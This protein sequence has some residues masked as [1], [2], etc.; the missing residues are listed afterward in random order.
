MEKTFIGSSQ[1]M[2]SMKAFSLESFLFYHYSW[3][4]IGMLDNTIDHIDYT[5]VYIVDYTVRS[6]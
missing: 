5:T 6:L 2:K 4:M 3:D 1:I